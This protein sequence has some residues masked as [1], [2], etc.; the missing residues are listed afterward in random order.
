MKYSLLFISVLIVLSCAEEKDTAI[1]TNEIGKK[2]ELAAVNR[3]NGSVP[4]DNPIFVALKRNDLSFEEAD[5][6]YR[7]NIEK[8]INQDYYLNLQHYG[9][10]L[11][12]QNNLE[13]LG[14]KN[15]KIYYLKQQTAL[16]RNFPNIKNFYA[17][18]ASCFSFMDKDELK[19]ISDSFYAK[20]YAEIQ[21]ADLGNLETKKRISNSLINEQRLFEKFV[22]NQK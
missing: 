8:Y 7:N 19:T 9:F 18:L 6:I 17:L 14:D 13:K 4:G 3:T 21:K 11:V 22:N 16:K 5:L 20:N 12:M 15:Q 1:V 2:V 10:M